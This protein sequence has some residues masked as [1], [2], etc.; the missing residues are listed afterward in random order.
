MR[1]V[2]YLL[3]IVLIILS[4][5]SMALATN[6]IAASNSERDAVMSIT[7]ETYIVSKENLLI[8]RILPQTTIDNVKKSFNVN[9]STV[10]IYDSNGKQEIKQGYIGT[11]MQ[12][13]FD[14]HQVTY[15][16]SVIGDLDGDG[17]IKQIEVNKLIKHVVGLEKYQLIGVNAVSADVSGDGKITQK[18][19]SILIKYVVYGKLEIEEL[20]K[21][22]APVIK[23]VSGTEGKNG[24]YTSNVV[25]KVEQPTN[26]PIAIS[27]MT[28]EITGTISKEE[29]TIKNDE[30][31]TI[32]E[33]GIYE[34]KCYS[35]T[36]TGVKSILSAK[37]IKIDKSAPASAI[38]IA[39][40]KNESGEN[41][42]FNS[43]SNQS[44]YIRASGGQ[45]SISDIGEVTI[46]ANGATTLP[47]G[48]K[49]PVLIEN[50][51][52]TEII[53]TTENK[54]GL[55]TTKSYTVII[56]K[57]IKDPGTVVT[58][59]ND[60]S[61]ELYTKDT[62]TN[63]NV[64]VEVQ[65]GGENITTTYKVEGA[66]SVEETANPTILDKEGISTITVINKD[67]FDNISKSST[68][69]KIDKQAP[70]KPILKVSGK[71]IL[72][73]S[74]WYTSDVQIKMT[75]AK[76]N[77][78]SGMKQIEYQ[79]KETKLGGKKEGILSNNEYLTIVEEGMYELTAWVVDEAGNKS[80]PEIAQIY[81]DT[82]NPVAGTMSLYKNDLNG[83]VYVNNSWTNQNIY[84]ELVE[85]TDELSGHSTTTYKIS[86]QMQEENSTKPV[87]I[88]QEGSYIITVTTTDVSGRT[89]QRIYHIYI[90]KQ[91]PEAPNIE[92][93]EGT[94]ENA[95]N[96]WYKSDVVLEVVQGTVDKGGSGISYTTYEVTGN[97]QIQETGISDHGTIF[98]RQDGIYT[99]NV[100]NY[101]EAGNKSEGTSI[102]VKTDK[103]APKDIKI[104]PRNITGTSFNVQISGVEETSGIMLYQIYVDGGLYKEIETNQTTVNCDVIDQSSDTH[105]I[106]VNIKDLAGNIGTETI[107]VHM[108]R[109]E[110]A[111]I[112]YIEFAVKNFTQT[113]DGIT[114]ASGADFIIS[115]TSISD[116]TKYIQVGSS[117]SQTIGEIR[118]TIRLIRKDGSIVD[119]FEYY[120]ENLL[121]EIAQY[122]D[123]S[124]SKWEH[125][126]NIN[127]ANT[128]LSN[129]NI[130]EGNTNSISV[131]LTGKQNSDNIF[132]VNDKKILGT[133]TY[134]RLIIKQILLNGQKVPFKI[135]S[136][137]L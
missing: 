106:T 87:T 80:E 50:N 54:A 1:R 103:T 105:T 8:S 31:I 122:S 6:N 19:V 4:A 111:D 18:D 53:V 84:A 3:L 55:T 32:E 124:G 46:E 76:E 21:P 108:G 63:Q 128:V 37:T 27:K 99:I 121:F 134:T 104:E 56:D 109:L 118:G 119:S 58:K 126:A 137:I 47:K 89:S 5:G 135:T 25:L 17:E 26:S 93:I 59:L 67:E 97:A 51:G 100:Y 113:K 73:N 132:Y 133:K 117:D 33:E 77:N 10:H 62:W 127:M 23:F 11:G 24:W 101:D 136:N 131:N 78:G 85:G 79:L 130:E 43:I 110:M 102:T 95:R 28:C 12:I 39:N 71:K 70:Q 40:L 74:E 91:K 7:S 120:P 125:Q 38:L 14:N 123:G 30:N 66:N 35:V 107:Q 52:T 42:Q 16:A 88:T 57:I 22:T 2:T 114:V 90:D 82:T 98:V 68:I 48:T 29:T 41:Y 86:G 92:V 96:E 75:G 94:K 83:Q 9:S 44:V 69:V 15:I 34:I 20:T 61:G 65:N 115:D 72:E 60:Q 129:Q 81:L 13:K 49:T 45:D 116:A 112:D 64:Y 36:Q